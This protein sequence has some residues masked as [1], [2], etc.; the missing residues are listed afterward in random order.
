MVTPP[1]LALALATLI[2]QLWIDA[3][4]VPPYLVP[5]PEAVIERI[6]ADPGFYVRQSWVT[7]Q[8]ALLGLALGGGS[9]LVLAIVLAHS[10]LLERSLLPL[11]IAIK[12]TP[13]VAVAPL[14]TIW[15]GFGILPKIL[16]A[17]LIAFFPILVNAIIGFRSVNSS[18][19]D[20][21]RSLNAST[22]QIF[23]NLRLPSAL[24]YLFS[25]LK[26]SIT[27]CLI[28]AL[29]GE[30]NG[31]SAGLGQVILLAHNN[32]DMATLFAAILALVL[33]GVSLT[34]AVNLCERQLLSWHD[35]FRE[36]PG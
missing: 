24:P 20:L 28:G 2:W 31:A 3:A 33:L 27:L 1:L 32:L 16:I 22:A 7:L 14:L 6:C 12:V 18:A 9:A 36:E 11:A 29:V 26:V 17:A 35:A 5:A 30:W 19:L 13:I 4:H 23:F 21:L 34:Q 8:E 25:A 15:F 10:R